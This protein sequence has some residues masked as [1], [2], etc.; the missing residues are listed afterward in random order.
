MF[1]FIIYNLV[2]TSEDQFVNVFM[3]LVNVSIPL[4]LPHQNK[5]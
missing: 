4:L 2:L 1:L 5:H 3:Y